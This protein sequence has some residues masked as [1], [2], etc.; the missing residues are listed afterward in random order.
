MKEWPEAT[1]SVIATLNAANVF[2]VEG[3]AELSDAHCEKIGNIAFNYREKAQKYF[4]RAKGQSVELDAMKK[5]NA[6][7]AEQ[8]KAMQAAIDQM[9]KPKRRGRPPKRK[10]ENVAT[11]PAES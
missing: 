1:P 5:Q 10:V 6:E 4:E 8:L 9:N 3:L 2:S 7:L 11:E